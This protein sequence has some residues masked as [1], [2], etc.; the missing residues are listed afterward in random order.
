MPSL[1]ELLQWGMPT[2]KSPSKSFDH[3]AS[4]DMWLA[5]SSN[6]PA[7]LDRAISRGA[8]PNDNRSLNHWTPSKTPLNEAAGMG[9][10]KIIERLHKAGAR[11]RSSGSNGQSALSLAVQHQQS[12]SVEA[13][14]AAYGKPTQQEML[15]AFRAIDEGPRMDEA[16]SDRWVDFLTKSFVDKQ[17]KL[18][19]ATATEL[20]MLWLGAEGSQMSTYPERIQVLTQAGLMSANV[21]SAAAQSP[22]F[23]EWGKE[24][25]R[26]TWNEDSQPVLDLLH[27]LDFPFDALAPLLPAEDQAG[28]WLHEQASIRQH[29]LMDKDTLVPTSTRSSPRL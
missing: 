6:D 23:V 27:A 14:L 11:R 1:G 20:G 22:K 28:G 19:A 15:E 21:L 10:P 16:K 8:N 17:A 4:H 13:L 5:I 7:R 29:R 12:Q 25:S 24:L 26:R 2:K 9:Y 3:M 18:S